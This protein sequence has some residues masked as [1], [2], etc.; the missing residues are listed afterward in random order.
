M[1]EKNKSISQTTENQQ[2]N[3]DHAWKGTWDR[4]VNIDEASLDPL[5]VAR[6][7]DHNV[8]GSDA[9]E[10][11]AETEEQLKPT[12]DQAEDVHERKIV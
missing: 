4:P 10:K 12:S 9:A 3:H 8:R 7:T 5:T 1:N 6:M 11:S 2:P